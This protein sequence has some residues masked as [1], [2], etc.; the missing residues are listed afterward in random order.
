M[1]T[2]AQMGRQVYL[3]LLKIQN[4][5]HKTVYVLASHSH[6]FMDGIIQ[7]GILEN[8]RWS[9][10]RMDYRHIR[11]AALSIA[12]Q[13]QRCQNCKDKR[14]R[15]SVGHSESI[16]RSPQDQSNLISSNWMKTRFRRKWCVASRPHLCTIATLEI[17][18]ETESDYVPAL[19]YTR[20]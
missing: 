4:E 1:G 16:R 5:G 6:Y 11:S 17:E 10:S 19:L 18:D 3:D 20:T 15:I 13:F 8:S 12:L 9:T 2:R 14:L 7:H